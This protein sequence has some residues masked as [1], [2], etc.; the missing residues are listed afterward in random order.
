MHAR[1]ERD[2]SVSP[3][4]MHGMDSRL[5]AVAAAA[6]R[7]DRCCLREESAMNG[8]VQVL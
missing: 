5:I 4:T 2:T 8:P 6:E 1:G 7:S 3:G